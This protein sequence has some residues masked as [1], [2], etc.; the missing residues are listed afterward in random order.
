MIKK[1]VACECVCILSAFFFLV[2]APLKIHFLDVASGDCEIICSPDGKNVLI[3]A[4]SKYPSK[5]KE[6]ID[7]CAAKNISRFD[8]A[9]I[10][11]Y[12]PDN[13]NCIP[14]LQARFSPGAIVYDRGGFGDGKDSAAFV[15]YRDAMGPKRKT[16]SKGDKIVLD[17]GKCAIVIVSLNGNGVPSAVNDNDLSIVAVLHYGSFDASFGGDIAGYDSSNYKNIETSVAPLVGGIEVYK[18]HNGCSR[19]STNPVWLH[20]TH[21]QVAVLSVGPW[22]QFKHPNEFCI[23][24][25][26]NAGID[27]YW[28]EKGAGAPPDSSDNVWGNTSIE[29]NDDGTAYTVSGSGGS[30]T[31]WSWPDAPFFA[32]AGRSAP[33]KIALTGSASSVSNGK[34]EW[35]VKG[36][37][38]HTKDC[39]VTKTIK[40]ENRRFGDAAPAGKMKHTCVD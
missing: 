24:R 7:F 33:R 14:E 13:I 37:N 22:P 31:Y 38:Y 8:Y 4:G 39:P 10:S 3:D 35:S 27:C 34:F 30:K 29:V 25:L 18:V 20:V 11:H 1:I 2:A 17:N 23:E 15:K 19:N 21:P 12:D 40:E 26:H 6:I 32:S 28:T 36:T 9:I 16:A 5:C